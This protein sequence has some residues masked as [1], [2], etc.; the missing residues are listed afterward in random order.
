MSPALYQLSYPV[1]VGRL[2][3]LSQFYG[4]RH[5]SGIPRSHF[6]RQGIAVVI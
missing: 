6:E 5:H 1:M 4:L 3:G 2:S